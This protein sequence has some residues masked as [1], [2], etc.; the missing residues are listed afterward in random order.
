MIKVEWTT[1]VDINVNQQ[2]LQL[3]DDWSPV[4]HASVQTNDERPPGGP[5]HQGTGT[6]P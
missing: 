2:D 6:V 4:P 5:A 3:E 1:P